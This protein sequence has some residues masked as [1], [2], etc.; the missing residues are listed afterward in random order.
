M[1]TARDF[2]SLCLKEAGVTGVGQTPLPEDINDTFTLLNRMLAQWQKKRWLVPSLY[3]IAALGNNQQ[4]NLIGPGQYYNAARPDKVQAAYFVQVTGD[5]S[6]PVSFPL[7]PIWSWEDF[8]LVQLKQ[9]NSFP[10]YFFYDGQFPYGRVYIWP[11]PSAQYEI[12][13]ILK[14][15]IGFT[16]ELEDG[17]IVNAGAAY[18][19]GVYNNVD[20]VNLTGFGS[21]GQAN[22]TVAGNV[23][24]NVGIADPGDGYK[25]NDQLTVLNTDVGGTGAGFIWK[26]TK[27]TD[28]LDAEFNMPPEY[29]EAIH[30]NLTRRVMEMYNYDI[31]PSKAALARASLNTI[32]VANAQIPTLQMPKQLR[33]VRSNNFYIF[34]ADAR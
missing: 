18:T 21:G 7:I 15:P 10:I 28:D 26:V 3:E 32:K 8:A 13:L 22:I 1:T 20:L 16:V 5:A 6:N 25:I 33:N 30:Y 31:P 23:I 34:N 24:T 9:L 11:I 27:V 2:C 4:Y 14:S 19:N 29:E 17:S 12:H